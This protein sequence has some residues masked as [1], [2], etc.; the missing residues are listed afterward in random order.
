MARD[1]ASPADPASALAAAA[2]H[3]IAAGPAPLEVGI[4]AVPDFS[5]MS[6]TCLAEPLRGANRRAGRQLYRWR[7]YS[8]EGGPVLSSNG[9]ALATE[10]LPD[11]P[12][13]LPDVLIVCGGHSDARYDDRR[14]RDVLRRAA[15]TDRLVGAVSTASFV[16]A[17]AGLLDGRRCTTHWEYIESFSESFPRA[18]LCDDRHVIDGRIFT[19]G[20]GLAAIDAMLDLIGRREGRAFADDVADNF[21]HVP[22]AASATQQRR[23]LGARLGSTHPVL[24]RVAALMEAHTETPLPVPA[25]ARRVGVSQRQIERLFRQQLGRA[26][27]QHYLAIRLEKARKLLHH[28]RLSA[29]EIGLSCGFSTVSHFSRSYRRHFGHPP[30]E[31]RRAPPADGSAPRG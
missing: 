25:L 22:P 17:A 27:S 30:S 14:L 11:D 19:C 21:L 24:L 9:L 18:L 26:P 15:R 23:D 12:A 29:T 10:R 20:G 6:Y 3:G 8:G 1:T 13:A 16:L 2:W 4:V 5:L 7:P 28:S 31:A